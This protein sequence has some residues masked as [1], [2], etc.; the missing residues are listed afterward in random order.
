MIRRNDIILLGVVLSI[1]LA[2]IFIMY[3]TKSD[4]SKVVITIDGKEFKILDL[5]KDMHLTIDGDNGEYNTI[6]IK[7]GVVD[8]I[9]ANCPDKICVKHN[10]IH[11]NGETIVC[12]PHK[13]VLEIEDGEENGVDIIAQ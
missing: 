3:T 8:M 12:L 7:D 1:A 11:Y 4:G 9:D 5:N 2:T 13:V 10:E 6:E